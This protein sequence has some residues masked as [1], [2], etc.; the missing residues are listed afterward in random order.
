MPP[1]LA[2]RIKSKVIEVYI[3]SVEDGDKG[4]GESDEELEGRDALEGVH[5]GR[6]GD[7]ISDGMGDDGGETREEDKE[8]VDQA[9]ESNGDDDTG[10]TTRGG[11]MHTALGLWGPTREGSGSGTGTKDGFDSV[12]NSDGD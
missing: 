9:V 4:G 2:T 11:D 5:L 3:D 7:M 8:G 6:W 1:G 10:D 12:R